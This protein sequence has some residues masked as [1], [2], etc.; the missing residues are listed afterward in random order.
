MGLPDDSEDVETPVK[1]PEE[2]KE[3]VKAEEVLPTATEETPVG[4]PASEAK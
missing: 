1:K 2:V 4:I 3:E